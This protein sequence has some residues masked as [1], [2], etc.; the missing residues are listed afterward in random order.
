MN[1]TSRKMSKPERAGY[2][3]VFASIMLLDDDYEGLS[4]EQWGSVFLLM[5]NQWAKGGSLPD[6][7]RKLASMA[8]CTPA[9]L[10]DLRAS[11]P[12]LQPIDGQEGKV[13]IP[14]LVQEWDEVMEFYEA[15]REK[16]GL[17]VK[18]RKGRTIP[19]VEKSEDEA[20]TPG[21]P[22]GPP[23]DNPPNLAKPDLSPNLSDYSN[24]QLDSLDT[25][26]NQLAEVLLKNWAE[27]CAK[28][29][30]LLQKA[31]LKPEEVDLIWGYYQEVPD[32]GEL[33]P[34]AFGRVAEATWPGPDGFLLQ[35]MHLVKPDQIKRYAA[36]WDRAHRDP[37]AAVKSMSTPEPVSFVPVT[38]MS[39][40]E[41]AA[42][43]AETKKMLGV[44]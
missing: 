16:S 21:E 30:V 14:Y 20:Q 3:R 18:A 29:P 12:K 43:A 10:E 28:H 26:K 13:G 39:D 4:R 36:L 37:Y 7:P 1:P 17:G 44:E 33:I 11:W 8:K 23:M 41:A 27:V 42:K 19:K 24:S 32:Y 35:L 15:Q 31:K 9:E 34:R 5:L 22:T 2:F 6:D 25:K 40:A 38:Q